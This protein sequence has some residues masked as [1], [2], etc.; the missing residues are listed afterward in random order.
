MIGTMVL[1]VISVLGIVFF[2]SC[3]YGF[4]RAGKEQPRNGS[5]I[6][7]ASRVEPLHNTR[8]A[9]INISCARKK[10][11]SGATV[12]RFPRGVRVLPLRQF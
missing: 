3:L 4:H 7:F 6:F 10:C 2:L 5:L 1:A 12:L 8:F 11:N 9:E